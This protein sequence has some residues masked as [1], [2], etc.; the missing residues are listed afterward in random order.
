MGQDNFPSKCKLVLKIT[1]YVEWRVESGE[2]SG[3]WGVAV[4][5]DVG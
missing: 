4:A 5:L 2:W 3:E 1:M